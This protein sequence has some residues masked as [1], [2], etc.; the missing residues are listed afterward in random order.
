MGVV[1][2]FAMRSAWI[3]R[4]RSKGGLVHSVHYG[5]QEEVDRHAQAARARND[6]IEEH[7]ALVTDTDDEAERPSS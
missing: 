2:L 6:G 1:P 3:L 7:R 4:A 5:T